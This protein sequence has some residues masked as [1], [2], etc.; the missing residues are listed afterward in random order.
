M[1]HV[2]H[3]FALLGFG[4]PISGDGHFGL[5]GG[6]IE[7]E[8]PDLLPGGAPVFSSSLTGDDFGIADLEGA[9]EGRIGQIGRA[10]CRER[11]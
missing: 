10:S 3:H 4:K 6:E 9:E 8:E 7:P 5:L 11:V 2:A 1:H